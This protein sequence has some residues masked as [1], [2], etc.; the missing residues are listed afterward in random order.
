M[1]LLFPIGVALILLTPLGVYIALRANERAPAPTEEAVPEKTAT[2][3]KKTPAR[4][5]IPVLEGEKRQPAAARPTP[6]PTASSA[7]ASAA[8][9]FPSPHDIPVGSEKSWLLANYGRPNMVTTEVSEGRAKETFRYLRPDSGT[10]IVVH[11]SSGRVV[12]ASASA[13]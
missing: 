7:P 12:S 5:S 8:R 13:Y 1:T 9:S 4:P 10:E 6:M 3:A 2:A 11:L